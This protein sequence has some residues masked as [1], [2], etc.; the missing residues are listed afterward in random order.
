MTISADAVTEPALTVEEVATLNRPRRLVDQIANTH[1]TDPD[2][3]RFQ[4]SAKH[5]ENAIFDVL[6]VAHAYL[7]LNLTRDQLHVDGRRK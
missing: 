7:G 3:V 4:V 6:N 2:A 5:C 1:V